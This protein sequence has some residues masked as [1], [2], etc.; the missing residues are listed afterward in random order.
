[1]KKHDSI[2]LTLCTRCASIYYDM[3]DRKIRRKD[4][5]QTIKDS[6]CLCQTGKG[7]D[8]VINVKEH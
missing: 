1:M 6:C 5:K 4:Y 2:C 7:F 3:A 8:F